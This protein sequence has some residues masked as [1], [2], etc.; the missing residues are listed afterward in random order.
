MMYMGK[1]SMVAGNIWVTKSPSM[2]ALRPRNLKREMAYPAVEARATP[3]KVTTT[4]TINE[5]KSQRRKGVSKR[6]FS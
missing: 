5:L 6:S 4:E 2:Y 1:R 3:V